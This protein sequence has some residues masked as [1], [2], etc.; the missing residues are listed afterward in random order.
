MPLPALEAGDRFVQVAAGADT[1]YVLSAAGRLYAWGNSEYGQALLSDGVC[2]RVERPVEVTQALERAYA[3]ADA[4]T[5]VGGARIVKV[6]AGGSWVGVLD[7]KSSAHHH[8]AFHCL[9][10]L[11]SLLTRCAP[12]SPK[13]NGRVFT[14]GYGPVGL[15]TLQEG[16]QNPPVPVSTAHLA[17]VSLPPM[18]QLYAGH[19][20]AVAVS[21]SGQLYVWGLDKHARLGLGEGNTSDPRDAWRAGAGG[22]TASGPGAETEREMRT[23]EPVPMPPVRI[24][25]PPLGAGAQAESEGSDLNVRVLGVACGPETLFVLLE[26]GRGDVG[27]W[28]ES[29]AIDSTDLV[30]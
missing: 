13:G 6:V 16:D 15:G 4:D 21:R 17:R 22:G 7:S 28:N 25:D 2:D 1:S 19:D 23:Y 11:A 12:L 8:I 24:P 20:Y 27:R 3:A 29:Y 18:A 5:D 10:Q 26:D 30:N 14:A 9:E